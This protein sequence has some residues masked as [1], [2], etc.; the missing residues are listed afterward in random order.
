MLLSQKQLSKFQYQLL[1][2]F[3]QVQTFPNYIEPGLPL[4]LQLVFRQLL[5]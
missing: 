5:Q 2:Y 4:R 1:D 3:L